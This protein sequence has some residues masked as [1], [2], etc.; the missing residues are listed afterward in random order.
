MSPYPLLAAL[1][2]CHGISIDVPRQS[3]WYHQTS[4]LE[5]SSPDFL[6]HVEC[7][8]R[9]LSADTRDEADVLRK[10]LGQGFRVTRCKGCGMAVVEINQVLSDLPSLL[11]VC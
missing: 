10:I 1:A 3:C 4:W 8:L 5:S 2:P 9:I 7:V 6:G 11:L